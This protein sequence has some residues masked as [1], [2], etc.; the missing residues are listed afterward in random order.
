MKKSLFIISNTIGKKNL[1]HSKLDH[2]RSIL[3]DDN[4]N[5]FYLSRKSHS[6]SP[7]VTDLCIGN[8]YNNISVPTVITKNIVKYIQKPP[9]SQENSF[10]FSKFLINCK[11]YKVHHTTLSNFSSIIQPFDRIVLHSKYSNISNRILIPQISCVSI[12]KHY[13]MDLFLSLINNQTRDN[14]RDN[15]IFVNNISQLIETFDC[16]N[17]CISIHRPT[18]YVAFDSDEFELNI[19]RFVIDR[20]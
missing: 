1:I 4:K 9:L 20:I 13:G 7:M 8:D 15:K 6:H 18:D 5:V 14:K 17:E 10:H 2:Y 12:G 16:T 3:E 19:R 11:D